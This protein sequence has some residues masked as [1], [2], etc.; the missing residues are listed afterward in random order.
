MF[1][2]FSAI[3]QEDNEAG[4]EIYDAI[5]RDVVSS[6]TC[7][8]CTTAD[9][10]GLMDVL[11]IMENMVVEKAVHSMADISPQVGIIF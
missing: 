10:V 1:H 6:C 3:Q 2:H 4:I 5:K 7:L 11:A 8:L 9:A